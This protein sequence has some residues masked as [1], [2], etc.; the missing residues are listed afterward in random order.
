MRAPTCSN[1][2]AAVAAT[3]M[4]ASVA[5]RAIAIDLYAPF[6]RFETGESARLSLADESGRGS[7]VRIHLIDIDG[8]RITFGGHPVTISR[9]VPP[10]EALDVDLARFW[11]HAFAGS[12]RLDCRG[13]VAARL[14][15]PSARYD[16]S[17]AHPAG[18]QR[19]DRADADADAELLI[20]V[21]NATDDAASVRVDG[22][23]AGEA[24]SRT[25]SRTTLAPR[26][27][28]HESMSMRLAPD[29]DIVVTCSSRVATVLF[30]RGRAAAGEAEP[31]AWTLVRRAR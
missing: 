13:R 12:L 10:G 23:P 25:L 1:R 26:A 27:S 28:L 2:I 29:A 7:L 8:Q 21:V 3:L 19:F 17:E 11:S 16:L 6:V 24:G 30:E 20:A 4:I 22:T 18:E 9:A 31:R 14:S 15:L 5:E